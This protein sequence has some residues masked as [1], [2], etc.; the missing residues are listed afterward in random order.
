MS[1]KYQLKRPIT[2]KVRFN[3][4]ENEYINRKISE[5]PFKTFQNFARIMLLTGEI[6]MIDYTELHSLNGEV[7]R[8]GNNVNQLAKL[9]HLFDEISSEDIQKLT[10]TMNELKRLVSEK[11]QEELQKE[12]IF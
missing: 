4:E 9:A 12:N 10:D 1:E 8:I 11:L 2:R 3:N 7:N 6:K 5:S